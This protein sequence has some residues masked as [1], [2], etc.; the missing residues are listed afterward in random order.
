M[1]FATPVLI[2]AISLA[3]CGETTDPTT[4]SATTDT[5]DPGSDTTTDTPDPGSD[6]TTDTTDTTTPPDPTYQVSGTLTGLSHSAVTLALDGVPLEVSAD[7]TFTF[8]A[9]LPDGAPYE[10]TLLVEPT[11]PALACDLENGSGTIAGAD[12]TGVT[13]TCREPLY[14]MVTYSWGDKLVRVQD[15]IGA[16]TDG[17]TATPRV[18]TPDPLPSIE[19]SV[20]TVVVDYRRDLVYV[21]VAGGQVLVFEGLAT[22]DGTTAPARTFT[23]P[24]AGVLSMSMDV[25]R[26]RIYASYEGGPLVVIDDASTQSGDV[27]AAAEI[28]LG[29]RAST[30]DPVHDRLYVEG[31]F[32]RRISV[33]DSA[34]ALTSSSAPDRT[35]TWDSD[36][37]PVFTHAIAIDPCTDRLYVAGFTPDS[38]FI[39]AFDAASTIDGPVDF[40]QDGSGQYAGGAAL[41]VNLDGA[42]RL[43]TAPDSSPFVQVFDHPEAWTGA[44]NA[45]NETWFGLMNKSYSVEVVR[46]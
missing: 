28:P 23:V 37:G 15:D 11:C 7:G 14:R 22:M 16:L 26:D 34:S 39:T 42:G 35:W 44:S 19:S 25:E 46:Y 38:A 6:T 1:K 20:D 18:V 30:Y 41:P 10:V 2:A 4:D 21:G 43:Y 8:P 45:A 9:E 36:T 13:V 33:F 40:D 24:Y 5:T 27:T 17:V 32:G 31:F 29:G 12:A 3:A